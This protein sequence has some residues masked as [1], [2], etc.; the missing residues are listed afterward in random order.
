MSPVLTN[1]LLIIFSSYVRNE[2]VQ[3]IEVAPTNLILVYVE[4]DQKFFSR[5]LMLPADEK[6]HS[7]FEG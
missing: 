7:F 4:C 2:T 3:I 1:K 5:G 6:K